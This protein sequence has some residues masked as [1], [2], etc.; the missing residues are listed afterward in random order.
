MENKSI[1]PG[2]VPVTIELPAALAEK[3]RQQNYNWQPLI[4]LIGG[5]CSSP[6]AIA[7][8]LLTFYFELT[9]LIA[10][11]SVAEWFRIAKTLMYDSEPLPSNE[12]LGE[13]RPDC[14]TD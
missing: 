1:R 4:E 6:F 12:E 7:E 13:F 11:R 2:Y 8:T 14:H 10:C 9:P 3:F 5:D